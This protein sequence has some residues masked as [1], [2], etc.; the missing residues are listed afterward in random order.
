[1]PLYLEQEGVQ[2]PLN[3]RIENDI[4]GR[5]RTTSQGTREG[6]QIL[7]ASRKK[8]IFFQRSFNTQTLLVC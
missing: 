5:L 6:F 1:M 8:Y 2:R 3:D 7:Y 4:I